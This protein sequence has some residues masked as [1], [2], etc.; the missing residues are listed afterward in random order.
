MFLRNAIFAVLAVAACS[1]VVSAQPKTDFSGSWKLNT[2]KSDF[3]MMPGPDSRSDTIE[4]TGTT[5]K[6][7]ITAEGAQGKRAYIVNY[8]LDGTESV[9]TLSG[10]E[11]KSVAKWDGPSLVVNSKLKFQDN[12]VTIGATWSLSEDG[13]MLTVNNHLASA[14][15]ETDQKLIFDR[16][17]GDVA[18]AAPAPA[19]SPKASVPAAPGARPNLTGTWKLNVAKSDFGVLPG[20]DSQTNVIDHQEP[21]VK[22]KVTQEGA[23]GKQDYTITTA[24]DGKESTNDVGGRQVKMST[25]WEG[26]NLVSNAKLNFQDNEVIIK[27]TYVLSDDGKTLTVNAHLASA[28]GETDQ[29]MVFEKQ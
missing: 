1:A 10:N 27:S 17:S 3:G 19:P 9:N 8:A 23:Q 11:V 13:K 18:T 14:M 4:Q 28:M 25:A 16:Q 20:P 26:N 2:A 29:K 24:T 7:A 21:V 15:G 6:D 22:I 12:D 5:L